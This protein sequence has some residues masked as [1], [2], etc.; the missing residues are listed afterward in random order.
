MAAGPKEVT[1]Y[2]AEH[3]KA[4][5]TALRR[6]RATIRKALP[7]AEE[8]ISYKIPTYK[9]HG[10]TVIHF[11][12]WTNHVA[13]YPTGTT[14][15]VAAFKKEPAT[16]VISKGT[17]RFPLDEPLPIKLIERIAKFRAK[18]IAARAKR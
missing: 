14:A 12:G 2:I 4:T 17:I 13:L 16:N 6:I 10:R 15:V 8:T 18:E 7:G 1:E 5:Q 11:A 9:L 3:P